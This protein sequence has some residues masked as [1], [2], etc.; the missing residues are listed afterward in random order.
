MMIALFEVASAC[1][2]RLIRWSLICCVA[3]LSLSALE[4]CS[5]VCSEAW[6]APPLTCPKDT[7]GWSAQVS[8]V[9]LDNQH[10]YTFF[11][12][13]SSR[14]A[15][16]TDVNR[17]QRY[18]DRALRVSEQLLAC[19]DRPAEAITSLEV[20]RRAA[21]RQRTQL[22]G[23]LSESRETPAGFLPLFL[24]LTR[25]KLF[26]NYYDDPREAA[27]VH[28]LQTFLADYKD[29]LTRKLVEPYVLVMVC[30][31]GQ[32]TRRGDLPCS[33]LDSS[34]DDVLTAVARHYLSEHSSAYAF[35]P[36]EEGRF[37]PDFLALRDRF[38]Q[39]LADRT[40]L[41][42][43]SQETLREMALTYHTPKINLLMLREQDQVDGVSYF[44][45][46]F[47]TYEV[48]P[49]S[50][51][52]E[53]PPLKTE[54]RDYGLIYVDGFSEDM[55]LRKVYAFIVLIVFTL[56]FPLLWV[57]WLRRSLTDPYTQEV[58]LSFGPILTLIALIN[59]YLS[60]HIVGDLGIVNTEYASFSKM[61]MYL[62]ALLLTQKLLCFVVFNLLASKWSQLSVV[63]YNQDTVT[64]F[65]LSM[66]CGWVGLFIYYASLRGMISLTGP[67]IFVSCA[68]FAIAAWISLIA[69]RVIFHYSKFK[70]ALQLKA[71]SLYLFAALSIELCLIT[72][73][74]TYVSLGLG[75]TVATALSTR[76]FPA[77]FEP[78]P[79]TYPEPIDESAWVS[80]L[81]LSNA[82]ERWGQDLDV[83]R[84]E[85][86]VSLK[87]LSGHRGIGKTQFVLRFYEELKRRH[88]AEA[89]LFFYG[90]CADDA[91]TASHLCPPFADALK[92][93]LGYKYFENPKLQLR[94]M[95]E[96]ITS[97]KLLG[98]LKPIQIFTDLFGS[99][100]TSDDLQVN[101]D[102]LKE[103]VYRSLLELLHQRPVLFV[104]DQAHRIDA[105][106]QELLTDLIKRIS[107]SLRAYQTHEKT[108]AL[109]FVIV[110]QQENL[111]RFHR[112]QSEL[113][114]THRVASTRV[115]SPEIAPASEVDVS[116]S[117]AKSA[118][119][120]GE[121]TIIEL[122]Q[123]WE[124]AAPG[125]RHEAIHSATQRIIAPSLTQILSQRLS[126]DERSDARY[127]E[128]IHLLNLAQL[129]EGHTPQL[130][131]TLYHTYRDEHLEGARWTD[132]NRRVGSWSDE[133]PQAKLILALTEDVR[134]RYDALDQLE[135]AHHQGLSDGELSQ[136]L[137]ICAHLSSSREIS[138]IDPLVIQ[139]ITQRPEWEVLDKL[140]QL[141]QAGWFDISDGEYIFRHETDLDLLLRFFETRAP[142]QPLIHAV[143]VHQALSLYELWRDHDRSH[144]GEG[145]RRLIVAFE[146]ASLVSKRDPRVPFYEIAR[147]VTLIRSSKWGKVILRAS[148][149]TLYAS[150]RGLLTLNDDEYSQILSQYLWHLNDSNYALGDLTA[151]L[152]TS[153]SVDDWIPKRAQDQARR[154]G[155]VMNES[156]ERS[157]EQTIRSHL[158]RQ[159]GRDSP[160]KLRLEIAFQR[161]QHYLKR[162][163]LTQ[164]AL[165]ELARDLESRINRASVIEL[166][167]LFNQMSS[168][169]KYNCDDQHL[170][171]FKA[172]VDALDEQRESS[173]P[174]WI[175]ARNNY[176]LRVKGRQF[177]L[178][179]DLIR[180]TM[181]SAHQ[182]GV[183]TQ[184]EGEPSKKRGK[185]GKRRRNKK[186]DEVHQLA[187]VGQREEQTLRQADLCAVIQDAKE[188]VGLFASTYHELKSMEGQYDVSISEN[189]YA[190]AL[191]DLAQLFLFNL[192][193]DERG[194]LPAP[195]SLTL[196]ARLDLTRLQVE[197]IER[198]LS[199]WPLY[200]EVIALVPLEVQTHYE[201]LI[202]LSDPSGSEEM[203]PLLEDRP[204]V[205]QGFER[206]V[207]ICQACIVIF[208]RIIKDSYHNADLST[209]AKVYSQ[210]GGAYLMYF[211]I[212][213]KLFVTPHVSRETSHDES[214]REV[215]A[216][217]LSSLGLPSRQ[218]NELIF[219]Y[220]YA[221]D[222]Y[223]HSLGLCEVI[224][225]PERYR[226]YQRS[227]LDTLKR[228]ARAYHITLR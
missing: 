24:S 72:W 43:D 150:Q 189:Q 26:E 75:L 66:C 1:V 96:Q 54:R 52:V 202:K 125:A 137:L 115:S 19:P 171:V 158:R 182:P 17:A 91:R 179:Q 121:S 164:E 133:I 107:E 124:L 76:V 110:H 128:I 25:Q 60:T 119:E 105:E 16:A 31:R 95:N 85:G 109:T 49:P 167:Q 178:G 186:R 188:A 185:Q 13:A 123:Y 81:D 201:S 48:N 37:I 99:I 65:L 153:D 180:E 74:S 206:V 11:W 59:A 117:E 84:D 5:E 142:D 222:A 228:L 73:H 63:F 83:I 93:Y 159:V 193:V 35:T 101:L 208:K 112:F 155:E 44:G 111:A 136:T 214:D 4:V 106:S 113:I 212:L 194:D 6:G 216:R 132:R 92:S 89:P 104:I 199:E 122:C 82:L 86:V 3:T 134:A 138:R 181:L 21:K 40:P 90:E 196:S 34:G 20:E 140:K 10:S 190:D 152:E 177:S 221:Q 192:G 191:Y 204:R 88:Q 87:W 53:T 161:H 183:F 12:L 9:Q 68:H 8:R 56:L 61:L 141:Y 33:R 129:K 7:A 220:R 215:S 209:R 174:V 118:A 46:H 102:T 108:H 58:P 162:T 100:V 163:P 207:P 169:S 139:R 14:S 42:R 175:Y 18:A 62:A 78:P 55:R 27:V 79:P 51:Q 143:H 154:Q 103:S 227:G 94:Q 172:I 149:H 41:P 225:T 47:Y 200:Q 203:T 98:T 145:A 57:W 28:G 131:S 219:T 22:N 184:A 156:Q 97:H 176:A 218:L 197:L 69:G 195:P 166:I 116:L 126:H 2:A 168:L 30:S 32:D 135:R 50:D 223:E 157:L 80:S 127:A 217:P 170:T 130:A 173:Y 147:Q 15:N 38:A 120:L 226:T 213:I 70:H 77:L 224:G 64:T 36:I 187:K 29:Q 23:V 39:F 45:V 144:Q 210:L 67:A 114:K 146:H 211:E 198:E 205:F 160:E 151:I 148:L 165:E 71:L